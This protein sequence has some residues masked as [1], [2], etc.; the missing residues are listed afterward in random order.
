MYRFRPAVPPAAH[1]KSRS[2]VLREAGDVARVNAT[3][4]TMSELNDWARRVDQMTAA[5]VHEQLRTVLRDAEQMLEKFTT[6]AYEQGGLLLDAQRELEASVERKM[7]QVSSE[8]ATRIGQV[9]TRIAAMEEMQ[10]ALEARVDASLRS[11]DERFA[12]IQAQLEGIAGMED[13]AAARMV[14][15]MA[16]A[17]P[18][19]KAPSSGP[20]AVAF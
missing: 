16:T 19:Q 9:V 15:L 13:R 4:A 12:T 20:A 10:K 7:E 11:A 17:F 14:E 6:S 3:E 5:T 8:F 18:A 2:V 1:R